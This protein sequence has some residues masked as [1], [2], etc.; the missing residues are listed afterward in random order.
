MARSLVRVWPSLAVLALLA[1]PAAADI[2]YVTLNN[3]TVMESAYQPQESSWDSSMV[4]L[5]TEVGNWIGVPKDQIEKVETSSQKSGFG[6]RINATT[7]AI[8]WSPNDAEDPEAAAAGADGQQPVS[9]AEARFQQAIQN[10]NQTISQV[11]AQRQ[12]QENYSIDQFVEPGETQGIPGALI[13]PYSGG[14][15]SQ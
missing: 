6:V 13:S 4:L 8:G 10:L 9:A 12:S 2:F 1:S 15:S 14:P 5:L 3:G 7:V 11:E